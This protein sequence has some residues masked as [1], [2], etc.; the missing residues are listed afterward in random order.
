MDQRF[1]SR[2]KFHV[3][4]GTV[5]PHFIYV[6]P[7]AQLENRLWVTGFSNYNIPAHHNTTAQDD[8]YGS[9][10]RQNWNTSPNN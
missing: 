2:T 9:A 8:D 1:I 3:T 4:S 6:F 5:V 7:R 10:V